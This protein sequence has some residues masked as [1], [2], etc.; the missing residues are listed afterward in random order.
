MYTDQKKKE[1]ENYHKSQFKLELIIGG[2]LIGGISGLLAILYR[3]VLGQID[4]IRNGFY[5]NPKPQTII[6]LLVVG[7]VSAI[8]MALLLKWAPFSNGSGIPQIRGELVGKIKMDPMPTLVSKFF[9]GILGALSGLALGREGPS[10]QLGGI[11][12]KL[13]SKKFHLSQLKERYFITAGASAGLAAAF[14][15]PIAGTLF[16]LEETHKSFSHYFLIPCIISTLMANFLSFSILGMEPAFSF[17]MV[18]MLPVSV[19]EI[20][21]IIGLLGGIIGSL[22]NKGLSTTQRV[23]GGLKLPKYQLLLIPIFLAI[24]IGLYNPL[25]LGGGHHM[26]EELASNGFPIKSIL[27]F[28]CIRMVFVWLSYGSGAQGG[29]FLPVLGLGA[30]LGALVHWKMGGGLGGNYYANF[31][32]LGMAA[33]LTSVIQAPLLSIL[34]VSEMSGTMLQLISVSTASITAYIIA[35]LL[36]ID[37]IYDTLYDN[38]MGQIK[39]K[40]TPVTPNY[41]LQNFLIPGNA[42]YIGKKL[43]EI[44]LPGSPLIITIQRDGTEFSP[45]G[46]TYLEGGDEILILI[47]EAYF[48]DFNNWI[49]GDEP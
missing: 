14:N 27:L 16:A 3:S 6:L 19:I 18:Q 49:Q 35:R 36:R 47:N 20:P 25:L 37:P 24:I 11:A 32:Y 34:L 22:F 23:L 41:T 5:N 48:D 26:V 7:I 2:F 33:V 29:I 40:E 12:A 15:A 1:L 46:E 17:P 43:S 4:L 13:F 21:I 8:I 9:G 30:L 31:L 39:K 38:L 10:I 45:N 28:L 44:T 42:F